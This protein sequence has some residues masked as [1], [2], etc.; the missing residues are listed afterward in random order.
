MIQHRFFNELGEI[1]FQLHL[2]ISLGIEACKQNI[3]TRFYTFKELI[4]RLTTSEKKG[5]INKALK[6]L[7]RIEMLIIDAIGYTPISK[8]QADLFFQLMSLRYEM[9]S[10][11]ITT[12]TLFFSW[13]DSFSNKIASAAIIDRL[14][15]HSKIFEI[16]GDSYRLKDYKSEKS[17]NIRHS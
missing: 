12:N 17:L 5:I 15:H 13:G 2:A 9:K 3:K 4:E 11:I 7:N 1:M 6:R 10:T 14:I 8:E 16:T